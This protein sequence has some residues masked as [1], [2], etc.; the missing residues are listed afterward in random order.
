MTVHHFCFCKPLIPN[1]AD[2][3]FRK[4]TQLFPDMNEQKGDSSPDTLPGQERKGP[5]S[6]PV[7]S[8][9]HLL[10]RTVIVRFVK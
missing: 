9:P 3:L 2:P 6:L 8:P 4:T 1:S 10:K 5:N 7:T